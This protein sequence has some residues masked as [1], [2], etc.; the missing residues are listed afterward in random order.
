MT[1]EVLTGATVLPEIIELIPTYDKQ[2]AS[3]FLAIA[4]FMAL[5]VLMTWVVN[6]VKPS[7]KWLWRFF[8]LVPVAMGI[9]LMG[10]IVAAFPV[11]DLEFA[12]WSFYGTFIGLGSIGLYIAGLGKK[13]KEVNEEYEADRDMIWVPPALSWP[14][15]DQWEQ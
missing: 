8:F 9:G 4:S 11:F 1:W 7:L 6:I 12:T 15:F 3:L 14:V 10:W 13:K 5:S 2:I